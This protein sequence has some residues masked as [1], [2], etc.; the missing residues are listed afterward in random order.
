MSLV[1]S[2]HW[3][4]VRPLITAELETSNFAPIIDALYDLAKPYRFLVVDTCDK[5]VC[6][7]RLVRFYFQF[8]DE[9]TKKQMS[10]IIRA[11]LDVE[12]VASDSPVQQYRFRVDLE[13]AKNYALPIIVG[14]QEKIQVNLIDRI[15]ASLAGTDACIEVT[16]IADPNAVLGVQKYLYDK[17]SRKSGVG[18]A[19]FDPIVDLIGEAVAGK[20]SNEPVKGKMVQPKIDPWVKECLKQGEMKLA[21]KLF[22]C[23]ILIKSNTSQGTRVVKNALPAAMNH[24]RTFKT[25]KKQQQ[26]SPVSVLRK[27]PR[28]TL[29]NNLLC[30]LWWVMP[31]GVL[32]LAGLRGLFNPLKVTS[33]TLTLDVGFLVLAVCLA[34]GLFAVFRKRQPIV[35]STPE[36]AQIIGLPTAVAKLPV[37]LGKVPPSRMQLGHE[38][39]PE[40]NNKKPSTNKE[41]GQNK[42]P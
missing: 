4:E 36:L 18:K 27:P 14:S 41:E 7:R 33:S 38:Q 31:I 19:V 26:P 2:E 29:R 13:L 3:V 23:Q 25:D 9:P 16:A 24:F 8:K 17:V 12:V 20:G 5:K 39:T 37:A 15:V 30:N 40:Q 35:L 10:N 28:Y 21:S 11:L 6:D 1:E 34:F 42:P 22:T 32:L